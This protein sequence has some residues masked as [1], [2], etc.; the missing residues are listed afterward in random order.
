[1]VCS[2]RA[3]LR[4]GA[5]GSRSADPRRWFC[6]GGRPGILRASGLPRHSV[7]PKVEHGFQ[8]RAVADLIG[9]RKKAQRTAL[10]LGR[11]QRTRARLD[12][13]R[14]G[15]H[16]PSA[17]ATCDASAPRLPASR[18]AG[19]STTCP[20]S[21]SQPAASLRNAGAQDKEDAGQGGSIFNP[22][23]A[24][25]GLRRFRGQKRLN[26]RPESIGNKRFGHAKPTHSYR[27][28]YEATCVM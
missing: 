6:G 24:T 16:P 7:R 27:R 13:N 19:A 2:I 21:R 18:A 3:Y 20:S 14:V 26:A 23:P 1:M 25:L 28:A 15:S 8:M 17:L 10:P 11:L 4:Y 9:G 5:F 12:S 22:R